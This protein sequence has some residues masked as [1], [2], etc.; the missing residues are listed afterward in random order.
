MGYEQY[1]YFC[2]VKALDTQFR[3]FINSSIH[4]SLALGCLVLI[5]FCYQNLVPDLYLILFVFTGSI[6]G[7][8]FIKYFDV[9][10]GNKNPTQK[11][12]RGIIALTFLS[13][14]FAVYFFFQLSV[15]T[16]LAAIFCG[17]LTFFYS[18][19]FYSNGKNLR[20]VQG[21]KIF[22]IALVCSIVTFLLPLLQ[23]NVKLDIYFILLFLQ[24]FIFILVVLLPFEIRDL[25]NDNISL[26][27]IP[28]KMGVQKTK[29]F[30]GLLLV[31]FV[32]LS[33][34]L[35]EGFWINILTD[36]SIAGI[37]ALFLVFSKVKQRE[38]YASFW[39]EAIPVFWLGIWMLMTWAF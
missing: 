39:V 17:L 28:Q 31:L 36:V 2:E 35:Y 1:A 30:G 21:G 32:L 8:N 12:F 33:M 27:T 38:Y 25:Q 26:G 29:F 6:C 5:S 4:L 37:A 14:F 34:R 3:F 15:W 16:Q 13:S 9:V 7:Y 23:A 18:F 22:I 20:N 24:R 10:K 11:S 19:S